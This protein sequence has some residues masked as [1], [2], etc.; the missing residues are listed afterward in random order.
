MFS[1]YMQDINVKKFIIFNLLYLHLFWAPSLHRIFQSQNLWSC[2][3]AWYRQKYLTTQTH[4]KLP[5][6]FTKNFSHHSQFTHDI[7]VAS[8]S[9]A[10]TDQPLLSADPVYRLAPL[11]PLYLSQGGIENLYMIFSCP[12]KEK[13]TK[14]ETFQWVF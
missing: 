3:L 2:V 14:T 10:E 1:A 5:S 12:I 13:V 6:Q 11:F 9:R 7:L 8:P 4:I